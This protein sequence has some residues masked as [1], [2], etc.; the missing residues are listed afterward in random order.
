MLPPRK[1]TFQLIP[2]LDLL[3]IVVFAQ[4]LEGR[5]REERQAEATATQTALLSRQ[6]DEALRQLLALREKMTALE[7]RA[8]LADVQ[9]AE[10]DRL[11]VQRDMIGEL[12]SEMFRVPAGM[13]EQLVRQRSAAGPGPSRDDLQQLLARWQSLQNGPADRLV[14]HLL[15]FG[16][17]RKRMDIWELYLQENG[18]CMFQVGNR[19]LTFRGETP[20]AFATR[21]FEAYKTLPEPKSLVLVL[22]SYGDAKFHLRKAAFDGLPVALERIRQDGGQ[23][24]RFDYAILGYRPSPPSG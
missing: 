5:I 9:S 15:T 1:L 6:L 7:A 22:L 23:H 4:Y 16:E 19:R 14:E 12:I 3:L 10:L 2:L 11:R 17:M 8:Q 24:S 13:L 21:L 20:E 18:D